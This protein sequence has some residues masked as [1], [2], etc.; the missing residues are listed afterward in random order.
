[1]TADAGAEG[2]SITRLEGS[3]WRGGRLWS[4]KPGS[5]ARETPAAGAVARDRTRH[6]ARCM[7]GAVDRIAGQARDAIQAY[8]GDACASTLA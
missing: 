5:R 6:A 3:R 2:L 7:R 1:M 4:R 8:R